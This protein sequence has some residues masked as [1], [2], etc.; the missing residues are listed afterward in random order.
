MTTG[1]APP[2]ATGNAGPRF[3]TKVGAYYL[4]SLL[5]SGEPRG[6]PGAM[7]TR[8]K[9]QQVRAGY[10]L[11][12]VVVRATNADGS[13][14]VLE[15]QA[16][17]TLD[18]TAS[19]EEFTDIVRRMWAA[20]QK[21][22]FKTSRYELAVAIARTST[23]IE[24]SCQAVLYW[25]RCL[26]DGAS[27]AAQIGQEGFSSK[28]M[29]NFVAVFRKNLATAGAPTDDDT[30]RL[31]LSRFQILVFD[32][33][34]PGSDY[35]H[36]ARERVRMALAPDQATRAADLWAVL[37]DQAASIA[38]AGGE[39]D[40]AAL[41]GRLQTT[42]GFELGPRTDLRHVYN[43]LTEAAGQALDD[44]KDQIGG[45]RLGRT[46][47]VDQCYAAFEKNRLTVIIGDGGLGKSAILKLLALRVNLEGAGI[48]LAPGRIIPGGWLQMSNVIGCPVS[49]DELFN[50]LGCGGGATLCVDNIDQIDD[51]RDWATVIDLLR[52]RW[53][54]LAGALL[55]RRVWT[56]MTGKP[57]CRPD[58][59][60]EG[61]QRWSWMNSAT[62]RPRSWPQEI[63][64]SRP[65]T[66]RTPQRG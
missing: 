10:P 63:R 52:A 66:R 49:R 11:D 59:S 55:R 2:A 32:S 34:S 39:L 18:F 16:K 48:F 51:P 50:E 33:E 20:A 8:V 29:R 47:L 9:L 24:R 28:E 62:P 23:R 3:E 1:V 13:P 58:S 60:R 6:L 65:S 41:A 22:E 17:R 38:I 57:G 30:V 7:V 64:H 4:L 37:I 61:L 15:I 27:F 56:Q 42:H 25:A 19:D 26:L 31:L 54:I 5:T 53:R 43:R 46:E 14:A 21:P 44:I 35:D 12:D 36:R 40:H 45:V